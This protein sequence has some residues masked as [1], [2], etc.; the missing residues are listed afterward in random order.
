MR[1]FGIENAQ[2]VTSNDRRNAKAVNFGVVYGISEWGLAKNLGIESYEAKEFIDRY[3][4]KYPGIKDYM[5]NVVRYAKEAGYV[6]TLWNRRR[7]LP[8]INERNVAVRAFA[9]RT[10]IN[11]PIQ[12][13]AAD[14][15]KIAM[16]KLQTKLNNSNIRANM[17][18]QVHDELVFEVHKDDV[19][20][21]DKLV[22]NQMEHAAI[23]NVPLVADSNWGETW[24]DAK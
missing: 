1:V 3:F 6:E 12:G 19:E 24:Y 10:A 16:N 20:L 22:K 21:L 4:E 8:E 18:L 17:L 15:L 14:I 11:S 7:Y 2:D 5:T 13:S 9:E 23:L